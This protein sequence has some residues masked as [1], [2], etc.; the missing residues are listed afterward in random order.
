[1]CCTRSPYVPV[2]TI[3]EISRYMYIR[4]A[5]LIRIETT[6]CKLI[7]NTKAGHRRTPHSSLDTL[8]EITKVVNSKCNTLVMR[9]LKTLRQPTTDFTLLGTHAKSVIQFVCLYE[10]QEQVKYKMM[11]ETSKTGGSAGF[12]VSLSQS[13][14]CLQIGVF[15]GNSPV[16]VQVEHKVNGNSETAPI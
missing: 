16:W 9:L 10:T 12:Q 7:H 1:M 6:V 13:Q 5:L 3:F 2:A 8:S 4:N 15:L 14:I 11:L